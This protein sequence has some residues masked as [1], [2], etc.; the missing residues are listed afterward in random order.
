MVDL[1]DF[2]FNKTIRDFDYTRRAASRMFEVVDSADFE[3]MDADMIFEFLSSQMEMVSFGDYLR[4]YIYQKAD[5]DAP[6]LS[7]PDEIY[8]DIIV[9]SFRENH[10]PFTFSDK[11]KKPGSTAKLWLS[12]STVHRDTV[13]VLGFGLKMS[14]ADVSEFLCKVIREGDFDFDDAGEVIMWYALKKGLP[15]LRCKAMLTEYEALDVS[16]DRK[17]VRWDEMRNSPE[18]FLMDDVN[19]W[20]YLYAL[21][22]Q[23]L[24]ETKQAHSLIVFSSLY[25]R[26]QKIIADL[27]NQDPMVQKHYTPIDIG[28]ADIE[29]LLCSGI[30][31]TKDGNLQ[32]MSASVLEKQFRQRRMSRQR[33]NKIQTLKNPVERFDI[34]TLLFFIYAETV[35]PDW[36]TE[37]Y[38]QFLDEG[39]KLLE[40]CHMVGIYPANPYETFILMCLLSEDPMDVYAQI[41]EMSYLNGD[42][43]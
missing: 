4:R 21:K 43:E 20:N 25:A 42:E 27:Y 13:F 16:S 8:I 30:P 7:V 12:Q 6:F 29:K 22:K 11:K 34:L 18:L 28:S 15:W 10:A 26:C 9:N 24:S 1:N 32:K 35:E 31:L 3:D 19:L 39:N 40:E 37:R 38:L 33:I 17:I 23:Q 41:W 14:A 2:D 36:P 5:I